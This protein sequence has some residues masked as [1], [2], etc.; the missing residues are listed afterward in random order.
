MDEISQIVLIGDAGANSRSETTEKR[1]PGKWGGK[2]DPYW[3]GTKFAKPV[4][5]DD[6]LARVKATE[7]SVHT[8][9][10]ADYAKDDFERAARETGGCHGELD[11]N[12]SAGAELLTG[13]VT[14]RILDSVGGEELVAAYR[15]KFG[16]RRGAAGARAAAVAAAGV[17]PELVGAA[18]HRWRTSSRLTRTEQQQPERPPNQSAPRGRWRSRRTQRRRQHGA[19]WFPRRGALAVPSLPK[20]PSARRRRHTARRPAAGPSA[21]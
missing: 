15:E 5:F 20:T 16:A 1:V 8:F 21:S 6:Q 17:A 2:G 18:R 11:V 13:A 9:Y 19:G 10:V 7:I 3:K 12:S 14:T 4:Y